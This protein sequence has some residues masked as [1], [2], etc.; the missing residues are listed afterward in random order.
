ML[1]LIW[2]TAGLWGLFILGAELFAID[3]DVYTLNGSAQPVTIS[4]EGKL[5]ATLQPDE[6]MLIRRRTAG[7]TFEVDGG[8]IEQQFG[9]IE[10]GVSILNIG[11]AYQVSHDWARY[12][13]MPSTDYGAQE[14][15][16]QQGLHHV[17]DFVVLP[18]LVYGF[19]SA[20]PGTVTEGNSDSRLDLDA[21]SPSRRTPVERRHLLNSELMQEYGWAG[22]LVPVAI[23]FGVWCI[24]LKFFGLA[25]VKGFHGAVAGMER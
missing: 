12:S 6:S 5:L 8:Q 24:G 19:D 16:H 25:A 13:S 23:L 20:P 21:R 17:S 14:D 2:L 22:V 15:Y 9:P 7:D 1:F 18:W 11:D 4:C 3:A 10:A